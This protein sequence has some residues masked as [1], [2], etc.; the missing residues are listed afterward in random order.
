MIKQRN[1]HLGFITMGQNANTLLVT[2]ILGIE[3]QVTTKGFK[4]LYM[5]HE[6]NNTIKKPMVKFKVHKVVI[7]KN[8]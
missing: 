2:S 4:P 7:F 8:I 1:K 5:L 3:F 6:T